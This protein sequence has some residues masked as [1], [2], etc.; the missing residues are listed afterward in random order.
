MGWVNIAT[1][2]ISEQWQYTAL[3]DA[4]VE[5]IRIRHTLNSDPL[6][7]NYGYITQADNFKDFADFRRIYPTEN[8]T[9]IEFKK[10]P[11]FNS[12][13]IA[14]KKRNGVKSNFFWLVNVDVWV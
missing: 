11:S 9:V 4:S 12:R 5:W 7:I 1:I 8:N 13:R 6:F 14:I 3:I 2:P 10:P